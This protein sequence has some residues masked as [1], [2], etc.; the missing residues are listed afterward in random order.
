MLAF[1]RRMIDVKKTGAKKDAELVSE[2]IFGLLRAI[3]GY[4]Q[5]NKGLNRLDALIYNKLRKPLQSTFTQL[6]TRFVA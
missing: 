5:K 3:Y 2:L 1:E 6:D 4:A